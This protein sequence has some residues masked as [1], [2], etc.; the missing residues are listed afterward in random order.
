[1]QT[2]L[3]FAS[4]EE[5]AQCLDRQRLGKQRVENLQI[6]TALTENRG[7]VSHPA[8]LMWRRYEWSLLQYQMAICIEWTVNRGYKDTCLTKTE[9]L[10]YK[11]R[12][13]TDEE[14]TPYWLGNYKLHRAHKSVLIQKDPWHYIPLFPKNTPLDLKMWYP[15]PY[16]PYRR[17]LPEG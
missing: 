5:S 2:F 15:K 10:Y 11:H 17:Q 9:A 14:L 6:M 3:P 1:M 8:T 4:Y 7:W 13:P 16:D 12:S